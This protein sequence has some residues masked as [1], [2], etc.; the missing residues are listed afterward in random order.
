MEEI[1]K[2]LPFMSEPKKYYLNLIINRYITML[3][4]VREITRKD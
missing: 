2:N 3:A 4:G 1:D